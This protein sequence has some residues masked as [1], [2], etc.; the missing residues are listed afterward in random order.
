MPLH[1]DSYD[2]A[3]VVCP[4]GVLSST[5]VLHDL[6]NASAHFTS[7]VEPLF[8]ELRQNIKAW[9]DDFNIHAVDENT[10]L[11]TID[12]FLQIA[13]DHNLFVSAIESL[14]FDTEIKWCGR[15]IV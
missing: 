12:R 13:E 9:V 15:I 2:V 1:P 7:T 10:V 11:D 5:R 3:G 4:K 6:R 14:F 8:A